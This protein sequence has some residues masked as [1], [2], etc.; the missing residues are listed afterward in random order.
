M[1]QLCY[2]SQA[3]VPAGSPGV[4]EE[5]WPSRALSLSAGTLEVAHLWNLAAGR[6]WAPVFPAGFSASTR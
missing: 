4:G 2:Y 1:Y 3:L 5:E 6:H